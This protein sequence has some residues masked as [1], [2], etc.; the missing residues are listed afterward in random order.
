[1]NDQMQN[2]EPY[3]R[4]EARR[5]RRAERR[6]ARGIPGGSTWVVGLILIVLGGTFLMQNMGNFYFPFTNWWA[7]FILIPALGSLDRAYRSYK[8]SGDQFTGFAR[9][10]TF[11]GVILLIVTGLFLFNLSWIYYGPLLL[12]LVGLGVLLNS[13]FPSK[14]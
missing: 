10:S 2:N 11:V 14:E 3:D 6:E 7:L 1:M 12:I 9:N 4:H 8:N 5:Q 13:V